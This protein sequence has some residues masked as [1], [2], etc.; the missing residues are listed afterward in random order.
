VVVLTVPSNIPA[1]NE[2]KPR[3][4]QA[5]SSH[6][7]TGIFYSQNDFRAWATRPHTHFAKT[8][9]REHKNPRNTTHNRIRC[10]AKTSGL[11][12]RKTQHMYTH[13][14]RFTHHFDNGVKGSKLNSGK[15]R[16]KTGTEF[17]LKLTTAAAKCPAK[18]GRGRPDDD[19]SG[20]DWTERVR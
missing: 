4:R 3:C 20:W 9:P 2:R 5:G 18:T 7:K 8:F 11:T 15:T 6:S 1:K 14:A 16:A 10:G 17:R 13:T 12:Q 19:D